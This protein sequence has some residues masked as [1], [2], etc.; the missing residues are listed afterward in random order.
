LD[1]LGD[2]FYWQSFYYLLIPLSGYVLITTQNRLGRILGDFFRKLTWS[3]W[4]EERG[5]ILKG[6]V[7]F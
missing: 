2:F 1:I 3:P 4:K 6:G 7:V 5:I